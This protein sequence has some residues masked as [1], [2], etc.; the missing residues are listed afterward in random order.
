MHLLSFFSFLEFLG[1]GYGIGAIETWSHFLLFKEKFNKQYSS[2]L[3]LEQRFQ[4]FRHNFNNIVNHNLNP[5]SKNQHFKMAINHFSDL[6]ADE[7]KNL[8][9]SRG[10][11][12]RSSKDSKK[13]V[14]SSFSGSSNYENDKSLVNSDFVDWRTKNAVSPVKN[15][16]QCGSCWSFSAT[17]AMEGAWAI[18]TG[19]LISLSEQQL[20]DCSKSYGNMGCNGGLMDDAF[21]FA[22]DSDGMCSELD[23]PYIAKSAP[24]QQCAICQSSVKITSCLDVPENNQLLLKQA[25][26]IGPVSVAIQADTQIFQSYSSGVIT[27][28]SCGTTLDH[29]VLVV[30]YGVEKNIPFWLVKNS[31]GE[32]W[33]DNGFVKIMRNDS[34]NFEGICGIA[35]QP[36]F[37]VV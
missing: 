21:E 6:T 35:M 8:Y 13:T 19:N 25:V 20:V 33:G 28:D 23:Y 37:P 18:K 7:F 9:V 36:S 34:S 3:E 30:G 4:I 22:V 32:S 15:Q 31:W 12:Q 29:G 26:S 1:V 24:Q 2:N 14:C 17:G 5:H 16:G 11:K 10:F 27:S